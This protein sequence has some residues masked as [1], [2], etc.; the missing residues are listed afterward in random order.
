M[1][2]TAANRVAVYRYD[3]NNYVGAVAMRYA[4]EIRGYTADFCLTEAQDSVFITLPSN[5][6]ENLHVLQRDNP[7]H[8][9]GC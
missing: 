7:K 8:F 4:L 1:S 3:L 5:Q 9:G 6:I 2:E